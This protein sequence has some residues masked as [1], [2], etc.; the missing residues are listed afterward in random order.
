M[1]PTPDTHHLLNN[2]LNAENLNLAWKRVKSNKGAP[3]IDGLTIEEF[4]EHFKHIG[5]DLVGEIRFGRYRP[6]PVKRVY[7]EKECGGMR[8]LGIPT[9]FDRLI[10]QAIVQVITPIFDPT[11]SNSSFGFRPGRSQKQAMKHV[12]GF[13][14]E[15][16][17]TAIDVDLSK[18]FDRVNHDLLMTLLGRKI[19]DKALLQLIAKYLRAGIVE[20]G[21]L[22][23]CREG[24]PQGGPLSPLLSNI[25]LD[26]LDKE[27]E[28]RGHKFARWA[29]D[30]IIVVGSNRAGDRVLKSI[31]NFIERKLKL[32]VNDQKSRVV[33]TSQCKFLGLSFRGAKIKWHDDSIEKFKREIKRLTGRS[34]G[35]SMEKKV[36]QL[37]VYL[38]GWINYF[39]IAEGYQKYIDLDAWIRRRLRMS[40]W[41]QWRKV[42]TKVRNLARR[43]VP[44]NNAIACGMSSKS[45]WRNSKTYW[46][47][48]ALSDKYFEESGLISLRDKWVDI[49]YGTGTADCG[50]A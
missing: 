34:M 42:R 49:H 3:G 41:K 21:V 2:V 14:R 4:Q 48:F 23:D 1:L 44:L 9:V 8:G 28:S 39:G 20:D 11:F 17:R 32:K 27:L 22:L 35:I 26:I 5:K 43:G 37:S 45:Y 19:Q 50:P 29:D 18:F 46:I 30:F 12:Q 13:V 25:V 7:I 36:K 38:R 31:T 47:N 6:Y 10:Q 33:P 16:R 24:V 15:G 40:Y